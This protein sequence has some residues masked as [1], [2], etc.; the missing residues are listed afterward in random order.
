MRFLKL[1]YPGA[2][3]LYSW[4]AFSCSYLYGRMGGLSF[5][6]HQMSP[7]LSQGSVSQ[8]IFNRAAVG[9]RGGSYSAFGL[10]FIFLVLSVTISKPSRM[11]SS[12]ANYGPFLRSFRHVPPQYCFFKLANLYL[13]ARSEKRPF[14]L[15]RLQMTLKRYARNVRSNLLQSRHSASFESR[16]PYCLRVM[17]TSQTLWLDIVE[18]FW[19]WKRVKKRGFKLFQLFVFFSFVCDQTRTPTSSHR[20]MSSSANYRPFLRSC[21]HIPTHESFNKLAN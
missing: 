15:L 8:I 14:V 19:D 2:I 5:L 1:S 7:K 13:L 6:K 12:W 21:R 11:M 17:F 20:M 3:I 18:N 16:N 9:V 10:L 4:I